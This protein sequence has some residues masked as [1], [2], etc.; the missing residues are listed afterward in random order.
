MVDVVESA[1]LGVPQVYLHAVGIN[2]Q[3]ASRQLSFRKYPRLQCKWKYKGIERAD[4]E[5]TIPLEAGN[6]SEKTDQNTR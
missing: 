6:R 2:V 4:S 5:V 3:S 1:S